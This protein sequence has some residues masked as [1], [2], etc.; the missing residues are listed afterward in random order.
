MKQ[1]TS[2]ILPKKLFVKSQTQYSNVLSAQIH[3]ARIRQDLPQTITLSRR[4]LALIPAAAYDARSALALNLGMAHLQVGQIV[5]AEEAFSE[6]HA[7]AQEAQNHHIKLL[8]I[9]F[10]SMVQ[11]ARGRLHKAADLLYEALASGGDSPANALP[12]LV[13]GALL[14]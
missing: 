14:L 8:A 12:H 6:A 13:Q 2:F 10:L 3:V 1:T 9:G 7:M 11:A 5:E 4:A